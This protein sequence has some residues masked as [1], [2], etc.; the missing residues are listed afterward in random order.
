MKTIYLRYAP[1]EEIPALP[2]IRKRKLLK[3]YTRETFAA[4]LAVARLL[5]GEAFPS[6][7]PFYYASADNENFACYRD[8]FPKFLERG[9]HCFDAERYIALSPPTSLFKS[10]RNMVPC[11]IS[12][13]YG[14]RGDNNVIVD[15]ASA[16]LYAALT[17][18]GEGKVLVGAGYL[19]ADNSV[20]TGFALARPSEF[21]GHPLLGS[22]ATAITLFRP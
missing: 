4:V 9:V 5:E 3:Y 13:E 12:I 11:F 20:E 7:I 21:E 15:S 18:P 19:H 2:L 1:D 17:A 16:L 22:A 14:L 8:V 6:S 10:M